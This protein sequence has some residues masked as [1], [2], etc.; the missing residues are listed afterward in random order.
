[1]GIRTIELSEKERICLEVLIKELNDLHHK[2]LLKNKA[3]I[4]EVEC[5]NL[6]VNAMLEFISLIAIASC[7]SVEMAIDDMDT[8]NEA[9]KEMI[10]N[11]FIYV[12]HTPP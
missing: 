2:F 12:N 5:C 3:E 4:G 7:E 11:K 8:Y 9:I 6:Y 10:L 1:M